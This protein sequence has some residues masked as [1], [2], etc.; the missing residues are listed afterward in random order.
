MKLNQP[1]LRY[2]RHRG[3]MIEVFKILHHVY[4]SDDVCEG[5]LKL[6]DNKKTRVIL[7]F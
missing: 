4:D 2:R 1:T 3:D 6:S 5:I 7:V